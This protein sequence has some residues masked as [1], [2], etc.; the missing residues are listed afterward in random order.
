MRYNP[1]NRIEFP[2][3]EDMKVWSALDNID[4]LHEKIPQIKPSDATRRENWHALAKVF[5][6]DID[7]F[8]VE[9]KEIRKLGQ[10]LSDVANEYTQGRI[11]RKH[12]YWIEQMKI[13]VLFISRHDSTQII[14]YHVRTMIDKL[15]E[16][17]T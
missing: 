11:T 9:Y 6:N 16:K 1:K 13:P 7:F 2:D 10:K 8:L 5:Y 17:H 4:V 15:K 12:N 3:V 14:H